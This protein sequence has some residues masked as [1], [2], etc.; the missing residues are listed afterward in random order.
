[1]GV[2][3]KASFGLGVEI[4]NFEFKKALLLPEDPPDLDICELMESFT[5]PNDLRLL[6]SGDGGYT[7][8]DN[9]Y[10]IVLKDPLSNGISGLKE[11]SDYLISWVRDQG[12]T[13]PDEIELVGG[14]HVY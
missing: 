4:K 10:Y 12:F 11:K 1:M 5:V 8:D 2:D 7:G 6:E 13:T 9:E 3:Y 14:L